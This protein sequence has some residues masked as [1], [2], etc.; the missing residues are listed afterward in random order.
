MELIPVLD[1][2]QGIAVQA[3][4]GDRVRYA[5]VTSALTPGI[6]GDPLAL[7]QAYREL[8]GARECYVADLDAIQGG[9]IQGGLLRGLA[10]AGPS[11]GLLI[12]AGVADR[13]GALQV[14]RLGAERVVV[15]LETLRSF[16]HLGSILSA[17]GP[18]RVVFSLD[19]RL[20][21]PV[22]HPE[23][24]GAQADAVS[25]AARAVAA[26]V[27][28]LLV[29]DLGRVGTG[30]GMDLQLLAALRER[31]PLRRLLAGGGVDGPADLERLRQTGCDGALVATALHRGKV[32]PA[33]F[34]A[35]AVSLS[36]QS[37]ASTSR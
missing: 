13:A 31:L 23:L 28:M 1:L 22:T 18:D 9:R 12:D 4:G 25:M 2:A 14:L 5:A 17:V 34:R 36:T 29:L 26:G 20:G 7:L 21:R 10:R 33:D 37:S 16:D 6:T 32:G 19:L 35:M 15:G 11:G 30:G 3:R 27:V 24:S 8:P